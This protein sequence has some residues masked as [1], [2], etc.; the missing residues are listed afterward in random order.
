MVLSHFGN[1]EL[2]TIDHAIGSDWFWSWYNFLWPWV[3]ASRQLGTADGCTLKCGRCPEAWAIT[4]DH[5]YYPIQEHFLLYIAEQIKVQPWWPEWSLSY[6]N[7]EGA[8]EVSFNKS[9]KQTCV[10][11]CF[12]GTCSES[13]QIVCNWQMVSSFDGCFPTFKGNTFFISCL[14]SQILCFVQSVKKIAIFVSESFLKNVVLEHC[15]CCH[16]C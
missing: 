11:M 2:G 13:A 8:D 4:I 3:L 1:M 5:F 6:R 15:H 7:W 10:S 9:K 16:F 14:L 12:Q